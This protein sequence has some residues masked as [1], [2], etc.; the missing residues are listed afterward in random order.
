MVELPSF[1][2]F[3][4]QKNATSMGVSRGCDVRRLA[5]RQALSGLACAF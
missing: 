4:I 5:G 1:H 2:V 3:G